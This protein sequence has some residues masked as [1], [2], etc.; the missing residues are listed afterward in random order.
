VPAE[1][2]PETRLPGYDELE[3]NRQFLK[4]HR[5]RM[6]AY[7]ERLAAIQAINAATNTS[8][9]DP[10][11]TA[12]NVQLET[13][14]SVA[15][16]TASEL[17]DLVL[18]TQAYIAGLKQIVAEPGQLSKETLKGMNDELAAYQIR[19]DTLLNR[20]EQLTR[21][22]DLSA[23]APE[24]PT[25]EPEAPEDMYMPEENDD[26]LKPAKKSV[27]GFAS[28]YQSMINSSLD[29]VSSALAGSKNDWQGYFDSLKQMLIKM[30]LTKALVSLI[31][32]VG[33]LLGMAA[34]AAAAGSG[35][36]GD[37]ALAASGMSNVSMQLSLLRSDLN[38]TIKSLANRT[39]QV[40]VDG[41]AFVKSTVE[42]NLRNS[43]GSR[44]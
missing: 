41:K 28:Y 26:L 37:I 39:V 4:V 31:P 10:Q 22:I 40:N 6:A 20:R 16:A 24:R 34:P 15:D 30:A 27:D 17:T 2:I 44:F 35:G 36:S 33:P 38:T 42:P 19:L 11:L 32:G 29:A 8:N 43:Q 21:G 12:Q 23:G 18:Q 25:Y 7:N 1:S 14:R 5:D 9:G 13:L 3:Q